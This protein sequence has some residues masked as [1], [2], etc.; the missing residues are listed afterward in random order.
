MIFY[1]NNADDFFHKT[2]HKNSD[3]ENVYNSMQVCLNELELNSKIFEFGCGSGRDT[4]FIT[5]K[6]FDVYAIDSSAE[7]INLAIGNTGLEDRFFVGDVTT[8]I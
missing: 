2:F 6:G 3:A 7:L 1:K 4:L 5:N 8:S